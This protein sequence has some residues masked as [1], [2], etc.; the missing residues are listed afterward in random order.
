MT[1]T[2]PSL[3][4]PTAPLASLPPSAWLTQLNVFFQAGDLPDD[5]QAGQL[6]NTI[7][8][9]DI[10][11]KLGAVPDGVANLTFQV[12]GMTQLDYGNLTLYYYKDPGM[13]KK[14][15][16]WLIQS[17]QA[18]RPGTPQTGIGDI[19][20]LF[21][22]EQPGRDTAL[23]F[24]VCHAFVQ[25]RLLAID[26]PSIIVRYAGRLSARLQWLDCKG[27]ATI[28]ILTPALALQ[29]PTAT[30]PV[31]ITQGATSVQRLPDPEGATT[32]RAYAFADQ[33]HGWLALGANILM[34][35]DG[36]KT[37]QLQ[38]TTDSRVE[39]IRFESAQAG[40]IL[41]DNGFQ[42]TQDGG[43]NWQKSDFQPTETHATM[44][45]PA[46]T[47]LAPDQLESFA[48]C[49]SEVPFAGV[50][51]SIDT[52]TGWA[53]CTS[54]PDTHF[55]NIQ[56]FQTRDGGQHWQLL[57]DHAPYG[58]YGASNLFFLDSQH[59]WLA[60][61]NEGDSGLFATTDGGR[62]WQPVVLDQNAIG[63]PENARSVDFLSPQ[64]GFVVLSNSAFNQGRD[65]LLGTRDGG[66][67]WQEVFDA[68]APAPWPDG[69]FQIF[70]DGHGIGFEQVGGAAG[71]VDAPLVTT[72][73]G[74]SWTLSGSLIRVPGCG[75]V[76]EE[77]TSL[78]FPDPE[79]GWASLSCGS[80]PSTT[81]LET[82]NGG[83]TWTEN[84]ASENSST[85]FV[86]VSFPTV[87]SGYLVNQAGI[88]FKTTDGGRSFSAVDQQAVHTRSLQFI[89]PNLG[90]EVRAN[91]LFETTDG[92]SS[93]R[94][95]P[96]PLPVQYFALLPNHNAWVVA[97]QTSS[98]TGI[99]PRRIFTTFDDG[100]TWTE[101]QF[102]E[103]PSNF[104]FP[105]Q[106]GIQFADGLHGW[107]RGG[108]ALFYTEVGG[109]TWTQIH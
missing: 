49:P 10:A 60:V 107:L 51:T 40:W 39:H 89:T 5:V 108:S 84:P 46:T 64:V 95:I 53:F 52:Q 77:I 90:W 35:A 30:L 34:T 9:K 19:A 88:L 69:P 104:D 2:T 73:W 15:G 23:F 96:F 12:P 29:S 28:P 80:D 32:I 102:G 31:P 85:G 87:S 99:P 14:A 92:G 58:R 25:V 48:F 78:S 68:P 20:L 76:Y 72:D 36:G 42:V 33:E 101:F 43:S 17:E 67:S 70:A 4:S 61:N 44:P 62:T 59:G 54:R 38:A 13:L 26:D 7:P 74:K 71:L 106:D 109:K 22:P 50:F 105:W 3:A 82:T 8:D 103:I 37:W 45:A 94:P 97:G 79:H 24:Q 18:R 41:T 93:W 1:D 21:L 27:N 11:Y 86:G 55:D 91:D 16:Q 83:Q 66:G 98:D 65:V 75:N 81:I 47:V 56:L 100:K 6:N 63:A 57:T